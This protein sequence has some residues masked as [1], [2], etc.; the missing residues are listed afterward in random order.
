MSCLAR[1]GLESDADADGSAVQS[2]GLEHG[3]HFVAAGVVGA[4]EALF[5]EGGVARG[6]RE[7]AG[8]DGAAAGAN[9]LFLLVLLL[10]LGFLLELLGGSGDLGTF[11]AADG[12]HETVVWKGFVSIWCFFGWD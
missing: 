11:G 5:Q 6:A 9:S 1:G 7:G 12:H 4:E 3:G 10:E 8:R 2:V